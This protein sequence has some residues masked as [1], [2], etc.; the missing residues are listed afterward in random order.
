MKRRLT[1][2]EAQD[3]MALIEW[4]KIAII[5]GIR[6][7]DY[8]VA[9]MN[10]GSRH[11]A[12]ARNLRLQGCASGFPDL[13]LYVP[14]GNYHGLFIELK[15]KEC[16]VISAKQHEW[17]AKLNNMGYKAVIA[18]GFDE[19]KAEIEKYLLMGSKRGNEWLL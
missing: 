16:G 12:E 17:I 14:R 9:S 1:P 3:Q 18:H 2:T 11:P 4:A 6:V 19:A 15:R 10:G 13:G 8:L 7:A 5:G